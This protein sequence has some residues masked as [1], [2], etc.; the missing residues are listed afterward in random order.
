[1]GSAF[2]VLGALYCL[3]VGIVRHG[4]VS[5]LYRCERPCC[6]KSAAGARVPNARVEGALWARI[7]LGAASK[8]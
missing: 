8:Q 7:F 5:P 4:G 6:Q 1:M 2:M 3:A